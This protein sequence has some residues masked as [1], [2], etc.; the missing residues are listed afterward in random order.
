MRRWPTQFAVI[1]V[2]YIVVDITYQLSFGLALMGRLYEQAGIRDVMSQQPNHA[3]TVVIFFMMIAAVLLKLAVEPAI[4]QAQY[5]L[6]IRNG[7]LVGIAAYGTTGLV[8]LWTITGFPALA[9]VGFL[10][11][12]LLFCSVS[13]GVAAYLALRR[14]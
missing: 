14:R 6:A 11:E 5:R 7:A 13:S 8:F 12:G 4:E 10:G 2:T 9:L 1:F 3:W